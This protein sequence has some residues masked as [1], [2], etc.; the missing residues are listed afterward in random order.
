MSFFRKMAESDQDFYSHSSQV[1]EKQLGD[2][3]VREHSPAG[4]PRSSVQMEELEALEG[5]N[6]Y[7]RPA[8]PLY[9][10]PLARNAREPTI[11]CGIG[12]CEKLFPRE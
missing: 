12:S 9:S 3:H 4:L 11:S 2:E 8:L 5:L 6:Q 7:A 10:R 1:T